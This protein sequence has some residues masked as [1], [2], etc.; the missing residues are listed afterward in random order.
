[1]QM[2]PKLD[3]ITDPEPKLPARRVLPVPIRHAFGE[4]T[5]LR[6]THGQ[7]SRDA[8]MTRLTVNLGSLNYR[9]SSHQVHK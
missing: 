1:M 7:P 3:T 2:P 8:H 4:N 9:P 6:P 5:Q